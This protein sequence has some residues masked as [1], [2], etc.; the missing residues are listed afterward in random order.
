MLNQEVLGY[1]RARFG[2]VASEGPVFVVGAPA[3]RLFVAVD[4][5]NDHLRAMMPV[6][7]VDRPDAN[8]FLRLLEANFVSAGEARYGIH[9]G[10]LWVFFLTRLSALSHETLALGLDQVMALAR[11]TGTSYSA[12]PAATPEL[13]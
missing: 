2:E 3:A 10:V 1:L 9:D 7:V 4:V 13:H 5:E 6:A 11:T 8:I 12:W